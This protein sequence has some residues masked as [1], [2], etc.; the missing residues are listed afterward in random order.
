MKHEN[1]SFK[2]KFNCHSSLSSGVLFCQNWRSD[3]FVLKVEVHF[4]KVLLSA[5]N[6]AK[7]LIFV[8][9]LLINK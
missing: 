7:C 1:F 4:K 6:L 2:A 5:K 8:E 9:G 3:N